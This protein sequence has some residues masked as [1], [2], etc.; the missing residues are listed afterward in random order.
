MRP[1]IGPAWFLLG[2]RRHRENDKQ[3]RERKLAVIAAIALLRGSAVA[4][5]VVSASLVLTGV[6]G[7]ASNLQVIAVDCES[8]PRK[9]AIQNLG[10]SA[11]AL[12][13]WKLESDQPDE[14]FDLGVIGTLGPG[15][16][17][18][19]FNGHGAPDAP[20][21][22]RDGWIYPWNPGAFDWVL[23]EDGTDFIRI[24]DAGANEVSR[25][26]CPIPPDTPT[27]QA[28]QQ[29]EATQQASDSNPGSGSNTTGTGG[30]PDTTQPGSGSQTNTASGSGAQSSVRARG[31]AGEVFG[32]PAPVTEAPL[33]A[34]GGQPRADQPLPI[35]LISVLVG[36]ALLLG[37]VLAI[38]LVLGRPKRGL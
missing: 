12:A 4:I 20:V 33:P 9:I 15:E 18:Y 30:G 35:P 34:G 38:S 28:T 7:A 10:D 5:L 19:V 8:H 13:G 26:P 25:M 2:R 23:N 24:V 32:P 14:V 37:G 3:I 16:T 31:A 6:A 21:L 11:Q 27:P 1:K 22:T 29:P 17:V 36:M